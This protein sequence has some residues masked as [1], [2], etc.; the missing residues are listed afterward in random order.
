ALPIW[1]LELVGQQAAVGVRGVAV[2]PVVDAAVQEGAAGRA[3]TEVE[4][5][6]LARVHLGPRAAVVLA[7]ALGGGV[8]ADRGRE[9]AG[10]RKRGRRHDGLP[11]DVAGVARRGRRGGDEAGVRVVAVVAAH[12]R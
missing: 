11:G 2:G 10:V 6:V 5:A 4:V 9:V 8:V 12:V 7:V 1:R 3:T